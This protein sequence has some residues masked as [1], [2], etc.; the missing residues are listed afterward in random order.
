MLNLMLVAVS[1]SSGIRFNGLC[2]KEKVLEC[3]GD[4]LKKLYET[5]VNKD[6]VLDDIP[7]ELLY[8]Q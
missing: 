6:F 8:T 1:Y 5:L 3:L 4:I 7:N 2:L